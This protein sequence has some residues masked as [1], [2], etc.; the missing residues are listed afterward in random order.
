MPFRI[1]AAVLRL[2]L[3]VALKPFL[4]P[5]F[6]VGF[7]RFWARLMSLANPASTA[8]STSKLEIE[9]MPAVR[10]RP[11]SSD[12]N[13]TILYFHGGAYCIGSWQTH[14]GLITHLAVAANAVVYAPNYRLAPEH[15]HPAALDDGV[16]AYRALLEQGTRPS[17]IALAGDSAG[18]GLALAT[19]IAARDSGLPLPACIVLVSPG[20]DLSGDY[21]S[22]TRNARK[23]PMIRPSWFHACARRYVGGR[24]LRDPACSPLFANHQ[25]LPPILIHVGTDEVLLDDSTRLA[26]RCREAGVDV[27]LEVF[28]GLWHEF[29]IH[30]GALRE[31]DEAV[32]EIGQFLRT[33]FAGSNAF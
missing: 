14:R 13:R 5:P 30:A 29:H 12:P 6:P 9:G 19:A 11:K 28:E 3:R 23:D 33:H 25:G 8:A 2:V 1:P 18:A 15:P 26:E 20:V 16:R 17:Q 7:Q 31:S 21:P 10:A 24:D 22:M 27:T 32:A 4:G